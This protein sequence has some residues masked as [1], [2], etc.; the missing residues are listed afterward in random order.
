MFEENNFINQNIIKLRNEPTLISPFSSFEWDDSS[1]KTRSWFP[2]R[3]R[4]LDIF[5]LVNSLIFFL[6]CLVVSGC[7]KFVI[8]FT[9]IT[10][11]F[12]K[13]RRLQLDRILFMNFYQILSRFIY[14]K[15]SNTSLSLRG[16]IAVSS[17]LIKIAKYCE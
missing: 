1:Q 8:H 11:H 15:V 4:L 5:L 13:N 16:I 12:L 6:S 10:R 14:N 7:W 9:K 3:P 2:S 17:L